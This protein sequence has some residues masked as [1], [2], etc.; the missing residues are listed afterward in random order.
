VTVTSPALV[1]T[2]SEAEIDTITSSDEHSLSDP[3][4][5]INGDANR[6]LDYATYEPD[7][8]LLDGTK[9]LLSGSEKIGYVSD[10]ISNAS[11]TFTADP[12]FTITLDASVTIDQ[13]VTIEF[14]RASGDYAKFI[15]V[16]YKNSVGTTLAT[17]S[18]ANTEYVRFMERATPLANVK[19]IEI[20]P[21]GTNNAYRHARVLD[22]YVDGVLWDGANIKSATIIEEIDLSLAT[23]PGNELRFTLYDPSGGFS[24][25]DPGG[26]YASLAENQRVDAYE[27]VDTDRIYMGRFYLKDWDSVSENIAS[28]KCVDALSLLERI[29]Y[30]GDLFIDTA[31]N[32]LDTIMADV[33]FIDHDIEIDLASIS[34]DGWIPITNIRE[35]LHQ[36][37]FAIEGYVTC[38]RSKKITIKKADLIDDI[39]VWDYDLSYSDI[40]KGHKITQRPLVTGIDIISHG[41]EENQEN[42]T[43]SYVYRNTNIPTG[44]YVIKHPE[45]I[46]TYLAYLS[47]SAITVPPTPSASSANSFT[48]E[49][50]TSGSINILLYR[51]YT[52]SKERYFQGAT[53]LPANVPD[54]I[55]IIENTT[56]INNSNVEDTAQRALDYAAQ[57]YKAEIGLFASSIS[58]GDSAK[59]DTLSGKE[60]WG[61]VEKV[62]IDMVSGFFQ[63][64]V[65]IG[66]IH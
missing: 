42:L 24:I 2:F 10:E 58:V 21:Y 63:K 61:V 6:F 37:A 17:D 20:Y 25:V 31:T 13:G 55:M 26:I 9:K 39:S 60:L 22:V 59:I 54:N 5:L 36:L 14:S 53:G 50:T 11:G 18:A 44:N 27:F 29:E 43:Y 35:A 41:F 47:T 7:R 46:S 15:R 32:V 8:W 16:R 62:E 30:L 38:S 49:V 33:S 57:R 19:I 66:E 51:K 28:F 64:V 4:D 23:I 34:I 1:L 52:H 12:V 45:Y 3:D 48:F 40:R 56:F 65:A